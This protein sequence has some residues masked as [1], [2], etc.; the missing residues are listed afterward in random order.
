MRVVEPAGFTKISALGVEEQRVRV[1]ADLT[2]PAEQWRALGDGYRVEAG[3][4]LWE[5]ADVLQVPASAVFRHGDGWALFVVAD[6]RAARRPVTLGQRG[7][8]AAQVLDGVRD[9]ETVIARPD[10]RIAEG[11]RVAARAEAQASAPKNR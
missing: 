9:G 10:D 5:A 3:F 8:L 2:S 1:I 4:V 11:V 6:G 7:G